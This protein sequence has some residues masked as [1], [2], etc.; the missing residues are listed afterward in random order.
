[1]HN[2]VE[3]KAILSDPTTVR[4]R[5]RSVGAVLRFQGGMSDRRYDREG[6]LTARYEVL[7]LR[8]FQPPAGRSEAVLGWKGPVRRS[9]QGYKERDEIELAIGNGD[10]APAA[11]LAA[12]GY[13][14]VHAIDRW[15]EVFEMGGTVVRLE[16]YPRMDDLVE[17]EGE[18][19]TIE[20]AIAVM[21]IPRSEFTA[22]SLTEF[23]ERYQARTGRLAV[24]A[25]N[26]GSIHPP[27]WAST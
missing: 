4:M 1:M 5:L 21:G 8:T 22:D 27:A 23:V 20:R 2:E 10:K 26:G 17:V 6:E 7:R 24:L 16:G 25:T 14:V 15:V 18:P 19:E 13:S 3:L 12:L 11:F 9:T